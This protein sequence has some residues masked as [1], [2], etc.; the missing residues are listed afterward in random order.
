M[1]NCLP[2]T[3]TSPLL[4]SRFITDSPSSK[5]EHRRT[6]ALL[7]NVISFECYATMPMFTIARISSLGYLWIQIKRLVF[8]LMLARR[9]S[10]LP[11]LLIFLGG[12]YSRLVPRSHYFHAG[13]AFWII[14]SEW[15]HLGYIT[16]MNRPRALRCHVTNA[17]FKQWVGLLLM[18]K[19]DRAHKNYLIPK[20]WEETH[21]REI[22]Y[23]PLIFQ[24][25][26]MICISH[27]V[28]GHTLAL[29]H[30][31]QNYFLLISC[32]KF[33]SYTQ[34]CCKL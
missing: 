28:G 23:G 14:W 19:I 32:E 20:I 27:H 13:Y 26:S 4:V 31:G 29:Q 22:F 7:R 8:T 6:S 5:Y 9:D 18:P 25:N 15:Y 33:H 30:G 1:H 17:S 12:R 3:Q 2:P 21:L 11:G 24:Q 16:D 34:M 10:T